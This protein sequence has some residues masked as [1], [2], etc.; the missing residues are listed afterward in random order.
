MNLESNKARV[1]IESALLL[2]G[3]GYDHLHDSLMRIADFH[4]EH[5]MHKRNATDVDAIAS[6]VIANKPADIHLG[7]WLKT[8]GEA[9][10]KAATKEQLR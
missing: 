2:K 5:F 8:I 6:S 9:V 7:V 1:C 3:K 10:G 4:Q